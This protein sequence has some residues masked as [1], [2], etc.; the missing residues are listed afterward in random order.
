MKAPS[1]SVIESVKVVHGAITNQYG[2]LSEWFME[3]VLKTGEG[4]TSVGSNPTLSANSKDEVL[5]GMVETTIDVVAIEFLSYIF[6]V[7]GSVISTIVWWWVVY[8]ILQF[9]LKNVIFKDCEPEWKEFAHHIR[10][11]VGELAV[12]FQNTMS[13]V[14]IIAMQWF[15]EKK[16]EWEIDHR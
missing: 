3:P 13:A 9:L 4:N 2:E 1:T 5:Y 8:V 16:E 14:A 7:A 12:T 11:G 6:D 15:A 10:L